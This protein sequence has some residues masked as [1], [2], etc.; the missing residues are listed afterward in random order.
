LCQAASH[1][2]HPLGTCNRC[3]ETR[4]VLASCRASAVFEGRAE[5]WVRAFKY[6]SS[7]I[8]A[9][10]PEAESVV[11][12]LA[13]DA[14]RRGDHPLPDAVIP[15]PLHVN[16]LRERGFNPAALL[17]A[18]IARQ[19]GRPMN[20][21]AL[22]RVRDT[23]SQTRLGRSARRRNIR[24]AFRITGIQAEVVWLVD[25]VVTTGN[26]LEEAA[27]TLSRGGVLRIH[28]ICAARTP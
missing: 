8:A 25:D 6:P 7:G 2:D 20:T 13:R 28:A 22:I 5:S 24:D 17:A 16:R 15:I 27:R 14:A 19:V 3:A 4:H 21:K 12:A 18:K 9:L 10:R 23:P 1:G 11:G 26:T